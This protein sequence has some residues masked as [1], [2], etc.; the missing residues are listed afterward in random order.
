MDIVTS[1]RLSGEISQRYIAAVFI[2]FGMENSTETYCPVSR[3]G[4]EVVFNV[5]S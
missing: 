5:S 3:A 4:N 1:I 2:N